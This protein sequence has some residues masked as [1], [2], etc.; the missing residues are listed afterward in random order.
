MFGSIKDEN[1]KFN[2]K[3]IGLGLVICE[4]IVKK[5]EGEIN[6]KST[7]EKGSKFFYSFMLESIDQEDFKHQKRRSGKIEEF[8]RTEIENSQKIFRYSDLNIDHK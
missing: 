5:F 6:F 8:K 7:F 2:I 1:K 3:G 4:L